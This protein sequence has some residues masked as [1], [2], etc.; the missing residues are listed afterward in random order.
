M[1]QIKALRA[2]WDEIRTLDYTSVGSSYLGI[3]T[4]FDYPAVF[5]LFQNLTDKILEFSD[6]GINTKFMMPANSL[7][8]FDIAS[9]KT[10]IGLSFPEGTR[11]Y[12][13]YFSAAPTQGV[14]NVS[15]VYG[16]V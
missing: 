8:T 3:G 15:M 16:S 4:D 2:A 1:A 12:V 11:I 13:R 10:S 5:L 9:N 6:D 7:F 14:V